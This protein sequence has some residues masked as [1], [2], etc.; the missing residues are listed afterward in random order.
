[1]DE[2]KLRGILNQF[3]SIKERVEELQQKAWDLDN[4]RSQ[5]VGR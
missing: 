1:M 5:F 2:R 3:K 4:F